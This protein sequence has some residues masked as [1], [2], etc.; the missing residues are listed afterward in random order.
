MVF[1][2]AAL[3]SYSKLSSTQFCTFSTDECAAANLSNEIHAESLNIFILC[4]KIKVYSFHFLKTTYA[5]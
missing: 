2:N 1:V 4:I 5:Q 3:V